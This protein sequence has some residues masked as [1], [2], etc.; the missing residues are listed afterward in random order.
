MAAVADQLHRRTKAQHLA[1]ARDPKEVIAVVLA[2]GSVRDLRDAPEGGRPRRR[3]LNGTLS[4]PD[5]ILWWQRR[6]FSPGMAP[7]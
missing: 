2:D 6:S 3:I 7:V 1:P 5:W 4:G